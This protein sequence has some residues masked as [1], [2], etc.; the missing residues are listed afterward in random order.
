MWVVLM[1]VTVVNVV[2]M[3]TVLIGVGSVDGG[4]M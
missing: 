4:E 3:V 2:V 1:M